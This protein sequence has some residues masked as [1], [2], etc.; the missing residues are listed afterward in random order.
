MST[1]EVLN[2]QSLKLKQ[3][4]QQIESTFK[5]VQNRDSRLNRVWNQKFLK[6]CENTYFAQKNN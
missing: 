6:N 5:S 3:Q 2:Q 1:L 4:Y